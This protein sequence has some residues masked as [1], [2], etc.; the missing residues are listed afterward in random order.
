MLS[1]VTSTSVA[2]NGA[3]ALAGSKPSR[4]RTNG[5][6]EPARDPN[7]T[8]PTSDSPTVSGDEPPVR[9]VVVPDGRRRIVRLQV[10]PDA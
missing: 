10:L 2:T 9:T 3:D 1:P 6:I 8:M 7:V 5:S 4:L